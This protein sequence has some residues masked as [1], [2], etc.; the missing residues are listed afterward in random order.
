MT[1]MECALSDRPWYREPWPWILM[2]GP[3]AVVVAGIVTVWLAV[4][5]ADGLVAEDYYRQGL[6]INRVIEREEAA[7][8]LGLVARLEPAPG[9]L[10][11]SLAGAPAVQPSA[12]F[13]QLAHATRAGHD[14]RLRLARAADGRYEAALP[15]LPPGR[16]R[17][18]I[19]DPQASWR[20]AGTW[21]GALQPF[22]LGAG[23]AR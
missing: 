5:S 9:R 7:R 22:A 17:V 1:T 20:I 16:W 23:P 19:E 13:V 4:S 21:T 12:L 11:L 6:A 18:S 8:Q 10:V 14:L 3:A 15:A 2:A